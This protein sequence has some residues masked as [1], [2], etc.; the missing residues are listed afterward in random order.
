MVLEHTRA[1][2]AGH[3]GSRG[4]FLRLFIAK[5]AQTLAAPRRGGGLGPLSFKKPHKRRPRGPSRPA[6]EALVSP[7]LGE[8]LLRDLGYSEA[9]LGNFR[10]RPG[11]T[12]ESTFVWFFTA[13]RAQTLAAPRRGEVLSNKKPQKSTSGLLPAGPGNSISWFRY[14]PAT[15]SRRGGGAYKFVWGEKVAFYS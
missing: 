15:V 10:G 11:G 5:R 1:S 7:I 12:P 6:P 4:R 8:A 13:K 3:E 14:L 2:G 9:T